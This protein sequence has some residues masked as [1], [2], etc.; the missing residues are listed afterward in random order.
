M[1]EW[2]LSIQNRQRAAWRLTG[3]KYSCFG[4]WVLR[5]A[6][7]VLC[8]LP[9]L[10]FPLSSHTFPALSCPSLPLTHTQTHTFFSSF[11]TLYS[12]WSIVAFIREA[13]SHFVV[14][15]QRTILRLGIHSRPEFYVSLC[16]LQDSVIS[17]TPAPLTLTSLLESLFGPGE[18][19]LA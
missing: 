9:A 3:K 11:L 15:A 14:E 13:S 12:S 17:K 19:E 1:G 8:G 18:D 16:L 7:R 5:A 10:T 2:S 4:S 6:C